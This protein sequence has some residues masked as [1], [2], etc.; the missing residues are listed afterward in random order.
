VTINVTAL[1]GFL[2]LAGYYRHFIQHYG[3]ISRPLTTLLKKGSP[4]VWTPDVQKAFDL[5]K[6]A[7]TIVPVLALP[8][9]NKQFVIETYA[10]NVWIGIV[11]M[12]EGHPIVY[13]SQSLNCTNQGCPAY[14][15]EC[16]AILLAVN[17]WRS[18]LQHK[19]FIIHTNQKSLTQLGEQPTYYGYSTQS[20]CQADG[21]A[22]LYSVQERAF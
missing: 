16:L 15:K 3:V 8:D 17:K 9:F 4:F 5:V 6:C 19:E 20:I 14:E 11:L 1:R 13:L 21:I 2:G 22:V 18:Y 7:L 12:Q 10:C